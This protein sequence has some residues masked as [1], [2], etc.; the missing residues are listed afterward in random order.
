[1]A[2]SKGRSDV[3]RYIAN[4]PGAMERLL[5]GAG[6]A[7]ANVIAEEAKQRSIS[8]EVSGAIKVATSVK[9]GKV[10]AKIQ[11]RG[12]GAY[13]APWLEY[14]TKQHFIS[15]DDS[16]SKGMSAGRINRI[17]KKA[18][19]EGKIGA[20]KSLVINGTFVGATVLHPGA[21]AHPFLRPALDT[22]EGEA[23]AAARSYVSGRIG[24]LGLAA[25]DAQDDEE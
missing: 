24:R 21:Q 10:S 13:L 25:T 5:R 1:M 2:T 9:D 6:R 14:G 12:K 22:K 16:Q 19:E 15:V 20:G 11:V 3:S 17:D 23:M 8:S 7:G 4:I 18:R